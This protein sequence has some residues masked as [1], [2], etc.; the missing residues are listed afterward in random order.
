M[1]TPVFRFAPSPNGRLHLGHAASA[2]LNARLADETGGRF[3]LR[4]EDIDFTRCR[5]EFE[6]AIRDDLVW[7]GLA[8]EVPV[9]RQSARFACYREALDRLDGRGLLYPC[10]CSRKDAAADSA[11]CGRDPDG[12]P[13][14]SGRCSRLVRSE[15][16]ARIARGEPHALRLRMAD[17]LALVD[18]DL[19]WREGPPGDPPDLVRANPSA[20]GDVV[21]KRKEFP[22]SYHVAVIVDDAFQ[23]VTHVVRGR[24]LYHATS[25]H[26]LLQHLLSLAAPRYFHHRLIA[27]GTGEK[28]SKSR[29]SQSLADLRA[30]GASPADVRSVAAI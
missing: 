14:Y 11:G 6:Q 10:F 22:A 16:D 9:L 19:I 23:G 15:S 4:I 20:W 21:L 5:P 29:G 26:R 30:A 1:S 24:D 13:L 8:W 17:A 27:D 12:A 7:L 18:D 2:L 25:L 3:L 28:L